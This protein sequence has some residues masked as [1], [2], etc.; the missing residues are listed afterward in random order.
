MLMSK[1]SNNE[2]N[3]RV[4]NPCKLKAQDSERHKCSASRTE[5]LILD[6]YDISGN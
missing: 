1:V 4:S 3:V 2:V 5:R 6:L